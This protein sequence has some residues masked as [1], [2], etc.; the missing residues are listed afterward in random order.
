MFSAKQSEIPGS[1]YAAA[2]PSCAP[3]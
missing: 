1:H 2:P 3:E